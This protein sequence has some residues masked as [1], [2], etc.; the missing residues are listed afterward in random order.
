M[1][2]RKSRY[3]PTHKQKAAHKYCVDESELTNDYRTL[4]P[5]K[6]FKA[7]VLIEIAKVC[8]REGGKAVYARLTARGKVFFDHRYWFNEAVAQLQRDGEISISEGKGIN[9]FTLGGYEIQPLVTV[10]MKT[11]PMQNTNSHLFAGNTAARRAI[12]Q[13]RPLSE[14][15]PV[16]S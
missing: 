8:K 16:R 1:S 4:K 3:E 10:P 2:N 5:F 11:A 6:Q 12:E 13:A 15:F 14:S 7:R 9:Y